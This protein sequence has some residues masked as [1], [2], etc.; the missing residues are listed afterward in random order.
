MLSLWRSHAIVGERER[1]LDFSV[2]TGTYYGTKTPPDQQ[3]TKGYD[4]T[5]RYLWYVQYVFK[6]GL[7]GYA[8]WFGM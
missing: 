4:K 6:Y 8:A 3:P 5:R 1:D 2:V 7:L